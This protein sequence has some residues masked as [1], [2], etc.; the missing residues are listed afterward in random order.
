MDILLAVA[1]VLAVIVAIY[2][3]IKINQRRGTFVGTIAPYSFAEQIVEPQPGKSN[4]INLLGGQYIANYMDGNG[5]A[6][7]QHENGNLCAYMFES[8]NF[9]SSINADGKPVKPALS[10]WCS[11]VMS[12]HGKTFTKVDMDNQTASTFEGTP[13]SPGKLLK[14][15][16]FKEIFAGIPSNVRDFWFKN[17]TPDFLK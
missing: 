3:T 6:I 7:I 17:W 15:A 13:E 9:R 14:S 1:I 10:I 2:S 16:T 4:V 11:G 8:M 12:L 5:M